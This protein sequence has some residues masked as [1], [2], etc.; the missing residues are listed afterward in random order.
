MK[1]IKNLYEQ[2]Y[3]IDNLLL[4]D[5]KAS[6]GKSKQYGVKVHNANIEMNLLQLQNMLIDKTYKTSPYTM[7]KVFEP[8]EREVFRLPYFPDR[9]THQHQ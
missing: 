6:K 9:I 2:I 7:F 4:A 8:K 5:A 3:S 1:R